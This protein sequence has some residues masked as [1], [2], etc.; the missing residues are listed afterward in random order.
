MHATLGLDI[1][2]SKTHSLLVADGEVLADLVLP[3]ANVSSV[4]LDAAGAV[5]DELRRALPVGVRVGAVCAGAAGAD[6][7]AGRAR[8]T[9]LL[10]SRFPDAAVVV[11]HDTRIILAA[12]GLDSGAVVIAGTGSAAWAVH[13]DGHE[14]RAGGW[15][16]LLGDEGSGYALAREAVRQALAEHDHGVAPSLLTSRL[17]AATGCR[18]APDLLD[19]FYQQSERRYWAGQA[20]VVLAAA[21][22]GDPAAEEAVARAAVALAELALLVTARVG[23]PGPVVLGGGLAV[24][25]PAFA[26]RVRRL[27]ADRGLTDLRVLDRSPAWGAVHLADRLTLEKTS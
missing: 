21:A 19:R 17:L 20:A 23:S 13:S 8:L 26:A 10:L 1:G 24:N 7:E 25:Q 4:G 9:E 2:G 16:Y 18:S 11:V 3:S 22:E 14:A 5:L 15:G 27:L 6:S 12:A